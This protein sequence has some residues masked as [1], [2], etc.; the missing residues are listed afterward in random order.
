MRV[1][2][3]LLLYSEMAGDRAKLSSLFSFFSC[4]QES[5]DFDL[6]RRIII[7][8]I[9]LWQWS[10]TKGFSGGIPSQLKYYEAVILG[11]IWCWYFKI[12]TGFEFSYW[13]TNIP[14]VLT[15]FQLSHLFFP[16]RTFQMEKKSFSRHLFYRI[17]DLKPFVFL[18]DP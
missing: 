17:Y 15:S 13:L 14:G 1:N 9:I 5:Q 16:V 4:P 8:Q 3:E 11:N 12:Y 2:R 18:K 6:L 10:E 7:C